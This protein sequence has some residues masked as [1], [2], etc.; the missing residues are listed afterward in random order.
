MT[1]TP[2]FYAVWGLNV[3]TYDERAQVA[4]T[5]V[6]GDVAFYIRYARRFGGPVL[7]LGSGTGRI[8]WPLA[9]AGFDAVGLDLSETMIRHARAKGSHVEKEIRE[10]VTFVQGTMADFRL[11]RTFR[12]VLI[13]FRSFQVL[14]DPAD[15]RRC[16]E[17]IHRH[18]DPAG[19]AIIDIFDPRL[20]LC[21][22]GAGD[23]HLELNELRHPVSG[24][25]VKTEM[26]YRRNDPVAQV[27]TER[28]RFT[29]TDS[30]GHIV[31]REE[32]IL[33]LRWTYR[34]EMRHLLELTGFEPVAEF[35]DFD[36]S[37]PTYGR[38]QIWVVRK[39]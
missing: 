34:H 24:N 36:E 32:E 8:A 27:L 3:E 18:L 20:E 21:Y 33:R 7:E 2:D 16:L 23:V 25:T 22:P 17:C 4:G 14:L 28:F 15:Q 19:R 6:E 13:P 29:E 10:R 12:L 38:E 30:S 9:E 1:D 26:L 35:S 39:R 5:S 31:R 11:E 37:P